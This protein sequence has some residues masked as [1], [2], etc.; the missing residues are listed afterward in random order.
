[1]AVAIHL[2]VA[3]IAVSDQFCASLGLTKL[4][5]LST[6]AVSTWD[7]GD[8]VRVVAHTM[9]DFSM[10]LREGDQPDRPTGARQMF[11]TLEVGSA[12]EVNAFVAAA[13]AGGGQVYRPPVEESRGR[14]TGA[15]R[16]PDGHV[17]EAAFT[18]PAAV[19]DVAW[20]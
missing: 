2:P 15:V 6:P 5:P 1:M 12:R 17:W 11:V 3:N 7:L 8:G 16:D 19:P 9:S 20:T 10:Y 18:D 13:I 14:F 4:L